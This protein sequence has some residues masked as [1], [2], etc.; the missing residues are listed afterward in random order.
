ML[1]WKFH[2]DFPAVFDGRLNSNRMSQAQYDKAM[3]IFST[4]TTFEGF[5]EVDMCIEAVIENVAL[6]QRIFAD[7][8]QETSPTVGEKGALAAGR[9]C[10]VSSFS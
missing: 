3:S 1:I 8:V 9:M 6:K 2:N 10:P 7:L 5:R 4:Q